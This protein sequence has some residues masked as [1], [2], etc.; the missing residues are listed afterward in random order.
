M[1]DLGDIE[2]GEMTR[3]ESASVEARGTERLCGLFGTSSSSSVRGSGGGEKGGGVELR[4][5]E[6]GES[7]GGEGTREM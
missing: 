2:R 3:G 7:T 4:G 1:A 5:G 6:G